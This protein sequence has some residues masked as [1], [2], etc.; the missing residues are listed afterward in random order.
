MGENSL[1]TH[2][3]TLECV[4]QDAEYGAELD[5]TGVARFYFTRAVC[6]QQLLCP[7]YV[8]TKVLTCVVCT[9]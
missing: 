9:Q 7:P 5:N 6:N 4:D 1:H 8:G 3:S 2:P